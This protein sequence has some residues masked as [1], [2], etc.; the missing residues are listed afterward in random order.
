[1]PTGSQTTSTLSLLKVEEVSALEG[2]P[3]RSRRYLDEEQMLLPEAKPLDPL[4]T[5]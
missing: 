2:M 4:Y 3:L 1:M 5:V